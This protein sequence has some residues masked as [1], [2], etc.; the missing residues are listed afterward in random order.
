MTQS[1][2]TSIGSTL[3]SLVRTRAAV[4]APVI[5]ATL[6]LSSPSHA[7]EPATPTTSEATPAVAAPAPTEPAPAEQAAPTTVAPA[8]P[9]AP[10]PAPTDDASSSK[11]TLTRP[12]LHQGFYLR[13]TSGPSF[14]TLNGH[15]PYG[16]ASLTNAGYGGM[17]AIGGSVAPGFVLAGTIQGT[18]FNAEFNGGPFENATVTSKGNT[19]KASDRASGGFG[20]VGV[21]VDW[22]P[23]PS[24]GWHVGGSTGVGAI[25][26]TNL[27]NERDFGGVN[28]AGSLFGGYDWALARKWSLGLQ[29][30][31]SGAT[32]TKLM[33]EDPAEKNDTRDTGYR[34]TPFSVGVQA[35]V[36]YF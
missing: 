17:I 30:V 31:V 9:V 20:M 33:E 19:S 15:G 11:L 7:Q 27:A 23:K 18:A 21:L 5:T 3:R 1:T 2:S 32:R 28:F 35:S 29:L 4:L 14:M 13:L 22:Y 36:L 12:G 26:L 10:T 16:S 6:S 25:V 34:L 8:A 24:G